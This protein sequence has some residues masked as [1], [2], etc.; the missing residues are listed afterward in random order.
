MIPVYSDICSNDSAHNN[1]NRTSH[2][3]KVLSVCSV[4]PRCCENVLQFKYICSVDLEEHYNVLLFYIGY[5]LS[6]FLVSWG[7]PPAIA[8]SAS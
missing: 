2:V 1:Y 3:F 5:K 7:F 8:C 4:F 6:L